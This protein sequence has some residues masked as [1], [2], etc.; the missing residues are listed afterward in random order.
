MAERAESDFMT[1]GPETG[2]FY[3]DSLQRFNTQS[4]IKQ[5]ERKNDMKEI[6]IFFWGGGIGSRAQFDA[7]WVQMRGVQARCLNGWLRPP[8][9]QL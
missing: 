8:V 2:A 6:I 5:K 9:N 4:W 1:Q 7:E 3:R